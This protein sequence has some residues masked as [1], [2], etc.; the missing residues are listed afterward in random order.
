MA[1][2]ATKNRVERQMETQEMK[3]KKEDPFTSP[4][5]ISGKDALPDARAKHTGGKYQSQLKSSSYI[6]ST[7]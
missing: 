1:T 7:W 5:P 4:W 6:L 2:V 3:R